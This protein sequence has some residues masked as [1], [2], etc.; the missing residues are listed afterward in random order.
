M[1]IAVFFT[2]RITKC[3]IFHN[4]WCSVENRKRDRRCL[5]V[6]RSVELKCDMEKREDRE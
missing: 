2:P 6:S 5:V 4:I 1:I 3:R